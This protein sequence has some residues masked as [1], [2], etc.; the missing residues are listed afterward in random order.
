MATGENPEKLH[1]ALVRAS[2]RNSGGGFDYEANL[3]RL[4][5]RIRTELDVIISH[6]FLDP[7]LGIREQHPSRVGVSDRSGRSPA[8][9]INRVR[10]KISYGRGQTIEDTLE[11]KGVSL[12]YFASP[13]RAALS[14][15]RIPIVTTIWDLGHRDLPH[16]PE[17]RGK[18]WMNRENYFRETLTRSHHVF[19]DSAVTGQKIERLFGV[20]ENRWSPLGLLVSPRSTGAGPLDEF[21]SDLGEG[22]VIYPAKRWPHKN[23]LALLEAFRKVVNDIPA[24]RLVLTGDQGG[25]A[26]D[27]ICDRVKLLGLDQNVV[28]FGYVDEDT[29]S[30]LVANSSAVLM[31]SKLGPTNI[32]PLMALALGVPAIV[33]NAHFFEPEV[34]RRLEVVNTDTAEEWAEKISA[35]LRYRAKQTPFIIDT[36]SSAALVR[37]V[38]QNFDLERKN[39]PKAFG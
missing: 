1:I 18:T 19:T 24:A 37:G 36:E 12:V 34:Q 21:S 2:S 26:Q 25:G 5:E 39:W 14:V 32:P 8:G 35:R 38:I 30:K 11:H 31:P 22:Y 4:L 9:L 28:D 23:H 17:F 20:N 10:A 6:W 3:V 27:A 29:L 7:E 33:S 16:F 15:K 13:N